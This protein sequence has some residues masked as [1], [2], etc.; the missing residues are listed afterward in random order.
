M[1]AQ[2][3]WEPAVKMQVL[4]SPSTAWYSPGPAYGP[5]HVSSLGNAILAN[6]TEQV[7]DNY[8][9]SSIPVHSYTQN[10][11]T[12]LSDLKQH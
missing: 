1:N 11:I 2:V 4:I 3:R 7:V 12:D 8:C 6:L 10:N 9:H 5:L